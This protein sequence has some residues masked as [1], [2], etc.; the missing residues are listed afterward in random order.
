MRSII[1]LTILLVTIFASATKVSG[2]NSKT[3]KNTKIQVAIL[4]DTSGSM[5][6]L[7]EQAKSR[8]WN[9][10]NTL[11]TLKYKG[12][13]PDI[14]ISLYE[15]GSY[16]KFEGDCI[17]QIT[18]LT[19]DLDWI[20]KELF[21][22]TTG[23]CD[24]YCGIVI[25]KAVQELEWGKNEADMKLVYIAGNESFD[26]GIISYR[27]AIEAAIGKGLSVNTIHCGREDIGIRDYWKDAAVRGN[28]KFFNINSDAVIEYVETPFD[29][30]IILCNEKLNDTYIEYGGS[31]TLQ[32]VNQVQQDINAQSI[33]GANYAERA[34][35]KT[36]QIYQNS[37]WDLIDRYKADNQALSKIKKEEL[38]KYLRNRSSDQIQIYIDSL[39]HARSEIQKEIELLAIKRQAFI[40]EQLRDK[41][42]SEG[43]DLGKA[44]TES[45]LSYAKEKGYQQ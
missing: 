6:G 23:G 16:Y 28:G 20:S 45:I 41:S 24:E 31:G 29:A 7:I 9:I 42:K 44:I 34:I 40:D 36:R 21:A 35:S 26:Q 13:A 30:R 14:E 3:E 18:P 33:S 19:S 1:L 5:Q 17:R 12:K 39:T 4:L 15:Y 32:K 37:S 43:D 22:L 27:R 11:T 38:P 10:V 8:L 25:N 2:E